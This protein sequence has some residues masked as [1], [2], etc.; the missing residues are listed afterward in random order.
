MV[1][2]LRNLRYVLEW[3]SNAKIYWLAQTCASCWNVYYMDTKQVDFLT[4]ATIMWQLKESSR[5]SGCTPEGAAAMYG[6]RTLLTQAI[7]PA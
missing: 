2:N 4:T 5:S 1:L 7:I 3:S 6:A